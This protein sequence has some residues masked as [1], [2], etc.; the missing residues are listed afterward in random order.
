MSNLTLKSKSSR[1][2]FKF[3]NIGENHLI[4]YP[5]PTNLFYA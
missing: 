3:K 2:F 5:A 1:L 4:Y